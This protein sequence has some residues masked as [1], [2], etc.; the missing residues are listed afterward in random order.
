LPKA[1]NRHERS[2]QVINWLREE[3]DLPEFNF[4]WVDA[5]DWMDG[6]G[7]STLGQTLEIR[8]EL[9]IQISDTGC[10]TRTQA[11]ETTIHEAAHV[12]LWEGGTGLLHG[13]HYWRCFGRMA[14][15]YE[16][17]GFMDSQAFPVD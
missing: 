12:S 5:I 3:F 6:E 4:E 1:R 13:D 11:I 7:E 2:T 17:H 15:A 14:D 10:R 8:G 16:H 9:T